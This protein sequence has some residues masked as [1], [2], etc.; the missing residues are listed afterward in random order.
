MGRGG[1]HSVIHSFHEKVVH[2]FELLCL[3]HERPLV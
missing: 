2:L 3:L 1:A